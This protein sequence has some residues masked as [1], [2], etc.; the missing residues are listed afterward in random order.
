MKEMFGVAITNESC[1]DICLK[2]TVNLR[3]G[4]A[5]TEVQSD[6]ECTGF[7]FEFDKGL[8][9]ITIPLVACIQVTLQ[10][11]LTAEAELSNLSLPGYF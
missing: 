8:F 6:D 11:D 5:E 9:I 4:R 1:F 10:D 3:T 2:I 7:N